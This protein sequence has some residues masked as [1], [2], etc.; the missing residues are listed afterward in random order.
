[1]FS[2]GLL[3]MD[4]LVLIEQQKLSFICS[5][6][7]VAKASHDMRESKDDDWRVRYFSSCKM[8][9]HMTRENNIYFEISAV[10]IEEN[11]HLIP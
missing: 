10:Q 7:D 9:V 2:N 3:N 5:V 8:F 6:E 4:T 11:I 1:M